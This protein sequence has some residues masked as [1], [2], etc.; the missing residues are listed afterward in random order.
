MEEEEKI[1]PEPD[2]DVEKEDLPP[3]KAVEEE[4]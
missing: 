1:V 4:V 3:E 2:E